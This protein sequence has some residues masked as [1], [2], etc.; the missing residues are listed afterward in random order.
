[1]KKTHFFAIFATMMCVFSFF[2]VIAYADIPN[3]IVSGSENMVGTNYAGKPSAADL[4]AID[5]DIRY[6]RMD[7]FYLSDYIYTTVSRL[8]CH[9][10][11]DPNSS[12]VMNT[13][14]YF[15]VTQGERVIILAESSG[16]ACAIFPDLNRA[17][18]INCN[19]LAES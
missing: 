18:W 7:S 12:D 13:N 6:P 2:T 16:Y 17:G 8:R 14:N 4:D 15:D 3:V 10:F 1:M 9:V 19:Y 5:A 11:I